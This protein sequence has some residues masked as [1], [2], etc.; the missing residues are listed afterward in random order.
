MRLARDTRDATTTT[1][2]AHAADAAAVARSTHR[3]RHAMCR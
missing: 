1:A 3:A 2:A